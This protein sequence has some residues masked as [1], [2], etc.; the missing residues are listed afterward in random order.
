VISKKPSDWVD[1]DQEAAIN[2]LAEV[3]SKFRKVE[4]KLS[5]RG[6]AASRKAFSFIY[7]DPKNSSI[8]KEFDIATDRIPELQ[9]LSREI[10]KDLKKQDLS[11]DEMLAIFAEACTE[12]GKKG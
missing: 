11:S 2:E 10:L 3:C 6:K 8:T 5:L 12:V 4:A 1:R 7:A 9:K